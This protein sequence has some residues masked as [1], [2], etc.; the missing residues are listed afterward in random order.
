[1]LGFIS[2]NQFGNF[3]LSSVCALREKTQFSEMLP[4]CPWSY[5]TDTFFSEKEHGLTFFVADICG[6]SI[7]EDAGMR[8]ID[9]LPQ[10]N[11]STTIVGGVE[12]RQGEL[13]WQ[14]TKYNV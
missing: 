2:L 9:P 1:M 5:N 13:P 8:S 3:F 7:Y 12:A 6:E 10:M 4:W 11:S 14:V